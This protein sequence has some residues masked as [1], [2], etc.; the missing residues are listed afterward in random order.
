MI[1]PK[2]RILKSL[3]VNMD[4]LQYSILEKSSKD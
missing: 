2:V 3:F 1:I 4:F